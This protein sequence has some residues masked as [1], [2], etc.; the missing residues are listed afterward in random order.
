[1]IQKTNTTRLTKIYE[2]LD[3]IDAHSAEARAGAILAGLGFTSEMQDAPTKYAPHNPIPSSSDFLL[4]SFQ[5][6]IY[7]AQ[8][9]QWRVEDE[10]FAGTRAIHSARSALAG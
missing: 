8:R 4:S 5:L 7:R 10:S 2:R 6:L 9:I 3:A 1:M